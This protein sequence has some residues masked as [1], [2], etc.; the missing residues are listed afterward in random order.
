MTLNGKRDGFDRSDFEACARGA[1]M[2]RG[3]ASAILDEVI[4]AVGRWQAFA[5]EAG[6]VQG[7]RD[8]VASS[9]R[10]ELATR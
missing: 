6:V 4:V 10:L 5:D 2:K 7:W 3:R 1:S 8:Q 9:L